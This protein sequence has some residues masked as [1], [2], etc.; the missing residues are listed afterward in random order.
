MEPDLLDRVLAAAQAGE[1]SDWEFKSARGGFPG[2]FW[3]TYSAMANS[4]GGIVVLGVAEHEGRWS[5]DGLEEAQIAG[6]QKSLWDGLHDRG[7]VS[8]NLLEANDVQLVRVD[9]TRLLAIRVPRASRAQRP[10]YLRGNPLSG[11]YRRRHEGDYRCPDAEVRR[12]LADA[13]PTPQDLRI[14]RGFSM[15]DLDPASLRQY[16]QR[17]ILSKGEDHPWSA[18][19]DRDL[20]EK[21]GGWRRD[22]VNGQEGITLA[23]LLMLG[24][25]LAIRDPEA[26]PSY[27]VDYREHLDPALRW[28]DRIYPDGT[29]EANL[30]QFYTRVWPKL[31]AG[32][33]TPFRLEGEQRRDVTPTHE[34]LREAFVNT[35]I[36][37][38]YSAPGG[39]V[40]ERYPDRF[41]LSNPG[42]LLVSLE[43]YQR[44]GISECRNPALQQMFLA[45]GGGERAGSGA[46]KI[47]AGWKA[48]HW[49]TPRLATTQEPDR[50]LL[51]LPMVSLIPQEVLDKIRALFG[52]RLDGLP[53]VA[54]QALATA[55]LEGAVSNGRLQE[56]VAEHP[57]DIS[58]IL[59]RLCAEGFLESDN[60]RRWTTYRLAGSAAAV[61]GQNSSL[62]GTPD[63]MP[64]TPDARAATP[65]AR[66]GAPDASAPG[67]EAAQQALQAI[68]APVS[69][70]RRAPPKVMEE[71]ILKLCEGRFHSAEQLA[72]LL[73]RDA[74]RLRANFLT[75]MTRDGRLRM[76]FPEAPN[77]P[78]QAY[79][80]A[81]TA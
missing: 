43:Q 29:W 12:M 14:V 1:G 7:R 69:S 79:I 78:D 54:I 17:F 28:T 61:A 4:D 62:P 19:S 57:W 67:V 27:F 70:R 2:S 59:A 77:R 25:D 53:T 64:G 8:Q 24:K 11:T 48:Q 73:R 22:R 39:V 74:E 21:L 30:F 35:L 44:G 71:A 49:R 68:A 55:A 42:T 31:G 34:A 81:D 38:D 65:D 15:E 18:L 66:P 47:R 36:H 20:L 10:I 16:R 13:D 23:G 32:L 33:P 9:D 52:A 75:P 37:A 76:R 3:E 6:L 80:R 56:L 72:S 40:V 41:Q 51:A 50:V 60:R 58:R 46:D 63:A 45:I 5:L 26:A